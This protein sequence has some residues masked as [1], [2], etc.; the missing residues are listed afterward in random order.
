MLGGREQGACQKQTEGDRI[1]VFCRKKTLHLAKKKIKR[2]KGK[3]YNLI[4]S[5]NN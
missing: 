1:A 2:L 3:C 5:E 4:Y